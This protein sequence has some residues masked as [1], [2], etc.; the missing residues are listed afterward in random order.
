MLDFVTTSSSLPNDYPATIAAN[1][2]HLA[3]KARRGLRKVASGEYESMKGWLEYGDALNEGRRLF[4]GKEN[5]RAFGAWCQSLIPPNLGDIHDDDRAAAMWAAD[6]TFPDRFAEMQ[7]KHPK[8]RTVRGLHAKWKEAQRPQPKGPKGAR[9]VFAEAIQS[10]A[11]TPK[12]YEVPTADHLRRMDSLRAT[13]SHPNS[14]ANVRENAQRRLDR[15]IE[16]FG[17]APEEMPRGGHSFRSTDELADEVMGL[18]VELCQTHPS[19]RAFLKDAIIQRHR[20]GM[21]M[22]GGAYPVAAAQ[23]SAPGIIHRKNPCIRDRYSGPR[24]PPWGHPQ[25]H[26]KVP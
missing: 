16:R 25:V 7:K 9:Q 2:Q 4:P 5:D 26:P 3:E 24:I 11:P 19:V 12:V 17:E 14:E 23:K 20:F 13:I 8:V 21:G 15:Y 10:E 18:V 1:T 22:E 6:M